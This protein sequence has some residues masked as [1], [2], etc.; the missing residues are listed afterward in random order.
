MQLRLTRL[1]RVAH[2][3]KIDSA[4][5]LDRQVRRWLAT[6]CEWRPRSVT[7]STEEGAT[8][9]DDFDE[10]GDDRFQVILKTRRDAQLSNQREDF[11]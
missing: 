6:L 11:D 4:C 8:G 10:G 7:V 9:D 3:K 2:K 1:G 5:V